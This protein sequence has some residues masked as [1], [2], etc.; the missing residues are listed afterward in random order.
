M[1]LAWFQAR[2]LTAI[3]EGPFE[4]FGDG[5]VSRIAEIFRQMLSD[6]V[7]SEDESRRI[8]F[9]LNEVLAAFLV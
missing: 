6:G 2:L 9:I 7:I 4:R 1:L 8:S 5:K 3:A